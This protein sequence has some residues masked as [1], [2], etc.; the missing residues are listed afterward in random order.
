MNIYRFKFTS[1]C[2]NDGK[3]IEYYC[4]I[5]TNEVIMVERLREAVP[6]EAY[7]EAIADAFYALFDGKQRMRAVHQGVEI[8]TIR[9]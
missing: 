3:Q 8:E 2:P 7:Q 4:E 5:K 6:S 9:P 1:Q